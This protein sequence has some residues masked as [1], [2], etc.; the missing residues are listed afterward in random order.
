[1]I[2]NPWPVEEALHIDFAKVEAAQLGDVR[3]EAAAALLLRSGCVRD[4]VAV[5]HGVDPVHEVDAQIFEVMGTKEQFDECM[6][7]TFIGLHAAEVLLGSV[8]HPG[9]F[10]SRHSRQVREISK[11]GRWYETAFYTG[12]I[13][14]KNTPYHKIHTY[15]EEIGNSGISTT[16]LF[17]I[18][19]GA[20]MLSSALTWWQIIMQNLHQG[21]PGEYKSDDHLQYLLD[22]NQERL[23]DSVM[24]TQNLLSNKAFDSEAFGHDTDDILERAAIGLRATWRTGSIM[25]HPYFRIANAETLGDDLVKLINTVSYVFIDKGLIDTKK[26]RK[27]TIKGLL[28]EAMWFIDANMLIASRPDQFCTTA[29]SASAHRFDRPI[30]GFP[31]QPRGFDCGIADVSDKMLN[32]QLINL[33]SGDKYLKEYH[34]RVKPVVET[35]F[36][37]GERSLLAKLAAYRRIIDSKFTHPDTEKLLQKYILKTVREE[38]EPYRKD[39]IEPGWAL[40]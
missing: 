23:L 5:Y 33:K 38:L 24:A 21:S 36:D 1:M 6:R 10:D 22:S 37:I 30:I 3:R 18:N 32:T 40:L 29:I 27:A 28:H 9:Y 25:L 19:Q 11:Q 2:N 35:G 31:E 14:T 4:A 13:A 39:S 20:E 17:T 15:I 26:Y 16:D 7:R 34:P 8:R 12:F